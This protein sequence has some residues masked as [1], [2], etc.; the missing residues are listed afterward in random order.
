MQFCE[1]RKIIK[2]F[3][4]FAVVIMQDRRC[5]DAVVLVH[6]RTVLVQIALVPQPAPCQPQ[7]VCTVGLRIRRG[8]GCGFGGAV[9]VLTGEVV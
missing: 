4:C 9:A 7:P 3:S 5:T 2:C 8:G 6:G 1:L